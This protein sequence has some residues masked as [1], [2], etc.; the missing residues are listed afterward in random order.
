VPDAAAFASLL[1]DI[2]TDFSTIRDIV[3]DDQVVRVL[4]D[5]GRSVAVRSVGLGRLLAP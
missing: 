1:T 5:A 3:V 2:P 4:D